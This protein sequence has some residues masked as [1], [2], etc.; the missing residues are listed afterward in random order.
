MKDYK[1]SVLLSVYFKEKPEYLKRSLES[2]FANTFAPTEVVLVQDGP[3]TKELELVISNFC[4]SYPKQMKI[5]KFSNNRGLGAALADGVHA[6]T[7]DL[8]A[9]MDTDDICHKNRFE[10]QISYLMEHPEIDLV[11]ANIVEYDENMTN[12]LSSKIVPETDFLIKQYI[13]KRNP[14]NH[15]S[16]VFRKSKILE[17]GNY[18]AMLYFEDYYLWCRLFQLGC[19]FHNIQDPLLD[20]RGGVS[21]ISRRGG[22]SYI[23]CIYRFQKAIYQLNII[24]FFDFLTNL[25]IRSCVSIIPKSFRKKIYQTKLRK[26]V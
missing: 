7:Y 3:L 17:A 22:Y 19:G 26:E 11:G 4:S 21:M 16:V 8:I 12:A 24:S 1:F 23:K 2:V 15:M 10:R 20:V 25:I 5:V 6:C 9:R 13:K 18:Q 14:F